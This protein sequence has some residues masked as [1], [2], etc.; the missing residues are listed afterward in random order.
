MARP[1]KV[2]RF[3]VNQLENL[4]DTG[5]GSPGCRCYKDGKPLIFAPSCHPTAPVCVSY[6]HQSG[7][8]NLT[9]QECARTFMTI[10]VALI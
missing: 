7:E 10:G 4:I 8:I 9:C 3:A 2:P 1:T 6:L 5:C